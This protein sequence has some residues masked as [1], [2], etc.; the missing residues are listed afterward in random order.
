MGA[1]TN[2][3]GIIHVGIKAVDE[4]LYKGRIVSALFAVKAEVLEETHAW[5]KL[6]KALAHG[7]HG[8]IGIWT[9]LGATKVRTTGDLSPSINE[10]TQCGNDRLDTEVICNHPGA[11]LIAAQRSIEIRSN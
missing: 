10:V 1:V 3:K 11:V 2:P 9:P 6:S 4:L 5:D 7:L 8:E